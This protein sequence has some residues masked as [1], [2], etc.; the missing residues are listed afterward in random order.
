[1]SLVI[2]QPE[3]FRADVALAWVHGYHR[4]LAAREVPFCHAR[5]P[6]KAIVA[7]EFPKPQEGTAEKFVQWRPRPAWLLA[8]IGNRALEE[9]QVPQS[10]I[11]T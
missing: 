3:S 5:G 2:R 4:N 9:V 10:L 7:R 6:K 8:G 1:M 11:N